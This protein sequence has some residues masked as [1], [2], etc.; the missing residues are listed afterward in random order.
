MAKGKNIC[1][2][3]AAGSGS[4]MQSSVKKQFLPLEG[5]AVIVR[6]MERLR[7]MKAIDAYL[8][9]I[10]PEDEEQMRQIGKEEGWE[11]VTF[12]HGGKERQ[13]SVRA[14]LQALPEGTEMVL[15]H[16]GAR[17]F[18]PVECMEEVLEKAK[19]MGAAVL[20]V[21]V[22]DTMKTKQEGNLVGETVPRETL[23][24]I[25]TP[26]VFQKDLIC[27]AYE[28]LPDTAAITDDAMAVER[29]GKPVALVMGSYQNIKLTT[30]EDMA[31]GAAI[32]ALEA[33][34][35]EEGKKEPTTQQTL[36]LDT[37]SPKR[38]A[39]GSLQEV[40]IYTDG[41]CSGNPGKGGYGVVL[42]YQ[43]K[44][45]ELSAGY[46]VTTNNRMEVLAVIKALELL[47]K[48]CRVKLYSDSKYVVDAIT[49]GWAEK[50]RK[51]HW[52]RTKTECASNVD[53]W[54]KLL[55]L[56]DLHKVQFIWVKGHAEN[57][58]NERCDALARAA[59][60]NNLLLN[61][62]GYIK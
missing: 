54:E 25:Q 47:K 60:L 30:P 32:L 59:I 33:G 12:V 16:D 8:M 4:R 21:P 51:N 45:K 53:L 61:D 43:G 19:E 6:T 10:A 58:E 3:M 22:K 41:A 55:D 52:M 49:K 14:A 26:Q 37:P 5:K 57:V 38:D 35:K 31:F 27:Q 46:A 48:P 17:P 1:L 39:K 20:A 44:R 7:R 34:A 28:A 36:S 11:E 62:E 9:V 40:E 29:M 2:V 42:L 50:W 15:I 13:D 24:A 23:W 18:V 56:L